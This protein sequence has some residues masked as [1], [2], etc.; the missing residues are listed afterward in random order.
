MADLSPQLYL[1]APVIDRVFDATR[2]EDFYYEHNS[3]FTTESFRRMLARSG[4]P[5]RR[6]L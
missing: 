2:L 4:R 3:H 6:S 1:E 5:E